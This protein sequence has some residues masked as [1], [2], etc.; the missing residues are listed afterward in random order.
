LERISLTNA[1]ARPV[2]RV[3]GYVRFTLIGLA[4][5][6]VIGAIIVFIG[7]LFISTDDV[8]DKIFAQVEAATGYRLRVSGPVH[9]AMF[10]SLDLVAEDVGV[11][12]SASGDAPELATAKK[13]KFSLALSTLLSGRVQITEVTLID[14]VIRLQQA[15]AQGPAGAEGTDGTP[16]SG[17]SPASALQRLSLDKLRIENGTVILPASG[18]TPG[19]QIGALMLEAS[20]P[21]IDDPL[22]F[23]MKATLDGKTVHAAGSIG[24]LG[25]FLDG[26]ATP[27]SVAIEA[28]SYLADRLALAGTAT[29]SNDT[30][31]LN[32]FT[33]KAGGNTVSGIATYSGKIFALNRLT[34]KVGGSTFAGTVSA[35]LSGAVPSI[36]AALNG[37]TLNLDALMGKSGGSA[38]STGAGASA[39]GWSDAKIDFSPLKAVNAKLK[40]SVGQIVSG[41]VTA[42]PIGIDATLSGGKLNAELASFKLYN[43]TGS[44]SL[45][46]DASGPAPKQAL[47]LSLAKFDAYPFL[48]DAAGFQSIE[49]TGAIAIDL[50]ASGASQR[51]MVSA[52]NGTAKL[53]FTDG[54]IRGMNIA[55]TMRS[56]TTGILAGWQ[57]SGTEKTDFAALG[58]SFAIAKGQAQTND[59]H[60]A[61]PLVR[62]TG[63]GTIDLPA[64]ALKFRVE[65]QV[66][67]SLE[68]Q[69]GKTDLQ[70]LSVPVVIAGP[71]AKPSIY[72]DIAG[73]LQNP[74]AAYEQLNKLGGGLVSL[75][76]AGSLSSTGSLGGIIQN[77][78]IN[79]GALQQ[80]ALKGL[81]QLLG[82]QPQADQA[83]VA[84]QLPA[85]EAPAQ[86]KAKQKPAADSGAADAKKGKKRQAAQQNAAD[87]NLAPEAAAQPL[88]Q[89]FL[90]N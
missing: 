26:V 39:A 41:A 29:Y 24:S 16:S 47:R 70:G 85:E 32:P 71:W 68:G 45:S 15:K 46:V 1:R 56:L 57:E 33:A 34:A 25:H 53:E 80:G 42:G 3:E 4:A 7:P 51:T 19:K 30:L 55:K 17:N 78:K 5:I 2:L 27:V 9:I 58:A 59:L 38:P 8:R 37:Q 23:D 74:A 6:A 14:P 79:K 64:Q 12:Q 76:G 52:L 43:G 62:T 89:N 81:G 44:A 69:G 67:A 66:V 50:T 84:D 86:P 21:A 10:P 31:T 75:P 88:M 73:I 83:P 82:N 61:G 49:G 11:A 36:A 40:L 35:D 48:K 90:G 87:P 60:L 65:P 77:G 13:L 18:G 63:A 28:P 54:A 72:P 20:L 22:S